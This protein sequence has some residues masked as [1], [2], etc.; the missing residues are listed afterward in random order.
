MTRGKYSVTIYTD[1]K[2]MLKR[3]AVRS[4]ERLSATELLREE[5]EADRQERRDKARR[6]NDLVNR[7]RM[8]A[9]AEEDGTTARKERVPP[10][11][12][13]KW[14]QREQEQG[15]VKEE[16]ARADSTLSSHVPGPLY[17]KALFFFSGNDSSRRTAAAMARP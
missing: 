10:P 13:G 5:Q 3:A 8:L 12:V 9:R 6:Y 17:T 16:L 14:T 7:N 4:G 11:V 15:R 1:D 2:D